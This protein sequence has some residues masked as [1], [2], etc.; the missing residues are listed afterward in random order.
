MSKKTQ[1]KEKPLKL[2]GTLDD[3]L[4]LSVKKSGNTKASD[5]PKKKG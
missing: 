5:K 3:I 4:R 2:K 1:A